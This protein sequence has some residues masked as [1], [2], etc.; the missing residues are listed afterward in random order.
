[1]VSEADRSTAPIN[2]PRPNKLARILAAAIVSFVTGA[3]VT[4][5]LGRK[6]GFVAMLA[7]ASAHELFDAPL[8]RL[9]GER[10]DLTD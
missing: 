4:R 5:L 3:I 7:G 10:L 9:L 2:E 1:M 8:A 6:A